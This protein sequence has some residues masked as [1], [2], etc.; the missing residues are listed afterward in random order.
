MDVMELNLEA[1][2]KLQPKQWDTKLSEN[3]TNLT[4]HIL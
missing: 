4:N 1:A 2:E 3:V